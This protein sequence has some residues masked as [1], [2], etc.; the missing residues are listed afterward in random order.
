V[1]I[2]G[3]GVTGWGSRHRRHIS[4]LKRLVKIIERPPL[5]LQVDV[6]VDVHGHL[7]RAVSDDLHDGPRVDAL[8]QQEGDL[9]VGTVAARCAYSA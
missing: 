7:D 2:L 1:L 6:A 5:G 9:L 3:A 4:P 8:G